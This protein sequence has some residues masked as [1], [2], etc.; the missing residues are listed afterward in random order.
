MEKGELS[1]RVSIKHSKIKLLK[2][3]SLKFVL[4]WIPSMGTKLKS[5]HME[6]FLISHF[7]IICNLI[8][9]YIPYYQLLRF[10]WGAL[11]STSLILH[12]HKDKIIQVASA[13]LVLNMFQVI[14]VGFTSKVDK[15]RI[16]RKILHN[17]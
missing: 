8:S 14:P 16:K 2:F 15:C 9:W 7:E 3:Y 17:K 4:L 13:W 6:I 5:S 11:L 1:R 10:T 12:Q